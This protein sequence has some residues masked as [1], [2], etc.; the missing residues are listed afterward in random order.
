MEKNRKNQM[1][2]SSRVHPPHGF[3][4]V[5]PSENN[6]KKIAENGEIDSLL[7]PTKEKKTADRPARS[8]T[9]SKKCISDSF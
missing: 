5:L 8:L 1:G 2:E 6:S 9:V 4:S 7:P 3:C